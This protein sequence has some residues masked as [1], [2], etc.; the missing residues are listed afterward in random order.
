MIKGKKFS[1]KITVEITVIVERS[2]ISESNYNSLNNYS[3]IK[4]ILVIE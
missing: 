4:C 1:L 2:A 3:Q